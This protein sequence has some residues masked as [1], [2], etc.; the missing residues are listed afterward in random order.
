MCK[1]V[2]ENPKKY[3]AQWPGSSHDG[4]KHVVPKRSLVHVVP[5]AWG[6]VYESNKQIRK[7]LLSKIDRQMFYYMDVHSCHLHPS[8]LLNSGCGSILVASV[9]VWIPLC[10]EENS[11]SLPTVIL[12]MPSTICARKRE[13]KDSGED[14][15]RLCLQFARAK[16][17]TE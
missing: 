16:S 13:C 7:M 1:Y 2:K 11:S 8:L 15:T 12:W 9:S 6:P 3:W 5:L 4:C 17:K 10:F 14:K